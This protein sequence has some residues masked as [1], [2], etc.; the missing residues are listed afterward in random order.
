MDVE[1]K[2]LIKEQFIS[3]TWRNKWLHREWSNGE[4]SLFDGDLQSKSQSLVFR[5]KADACITELVEKPLCT[6]SWQMQRMR[7]PC[8]LANDFWQYSSPEPSGDCRLGFHKGNKPQLFY[9]GGTSQTDF[10]N[11][12][13]NLLTNRLIHDLDREVGS[14]TGHFLMIKL[15]IAR[16]PAFA[17]AGL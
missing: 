8:F 3:T 13:W 11:L 1:G 17:R 2:V 7:P 5:V 16:H 4:N 9:N 10:S 6:D 12:C 15:K 14:K